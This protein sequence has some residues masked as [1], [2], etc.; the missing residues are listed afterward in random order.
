VRRRDLRTQPR[1]LEIRTTRRI[2]RA[3]QSA[4]NS[5]LE[6][7]KPDLADETALWK[8]PHHSE[9]C[10]FAVPRNGG[11]EG[12]AAASRTEVYDVNAHAVPGPRSNRLA[13]LT[14]PNQIIENTYR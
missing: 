6:Q 10:V 7:V 3:C 1:R 9:Y 2:L 8:Q 12:L 11:P 13:P 14:I 5:R 4:Q